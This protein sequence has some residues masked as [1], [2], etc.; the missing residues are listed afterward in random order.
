MKG[1]EWLSFRDT[2]RE[3]RRGFD[4]WEESAAMSEQKAILM[5]V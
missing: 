4:G 5:E 2:H 1:K 3:E